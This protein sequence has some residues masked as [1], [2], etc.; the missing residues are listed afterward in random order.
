MRLFDGGG[1]APGPAE[2]AIE[3]ERITAGHR[4]L[5][6]IALDGE[7]VLDLPDGTLLPGLIDAHVHLMGSGE[8]GDTAFGGGA[9]P[10]LDP[11]RHPELLP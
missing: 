6:T 2:I 1:N 10:Q 9:L 3:G 8:P 7:P 5:G 4:G 11:R